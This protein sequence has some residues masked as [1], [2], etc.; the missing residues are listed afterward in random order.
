MKKEKNKI[1]FQNFCL[2]SEEDRQAII[3]SWNEGLIDEEAHN[4]EII[5]ELHDDE[6]EDF[7][8]N[9]KYSELKDSRIQI[10][11][12]LGLWNGPHTIQPV[13]CN[14]LEEAMNKILRD[15]DYISIYEDHYGNLNVDAY[16]HDGTN[17]FI[18]KKYTDKGPRVLNYC[19]TIFGC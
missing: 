2:F 14:S 7:L 4:E 8:E 16:H 19:K 18:L 15:I 11:G 1:I 17:H 5:A 13:I 9:Y 3:D 12:V 6:Y 10:R